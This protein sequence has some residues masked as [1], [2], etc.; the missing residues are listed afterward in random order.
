MAKSG[1][2]RG[3]TAFLVA[4][5]AP[6]LI[7]YL[8]LVAG[9]FFQVFQLA[10]FRFSGVSTKRTFVGFQNFQDLWSEE[11]FW[12]AIRNSLTL[13]LV[14]GPIIL[15]LALALAHGMAGPSRQAKML[16]AVI[17]FPNVLSVVAVALLWR[18]VYNPS[19]GLLRGMG[20][21]G[22]Q[23]GWLG[24]LN[25]AFPAFA[26]AFIWVSVGFYA[27]LFSAAL[28]SIPVEVNE[29]SD[30]EGCTGW[31][32]FVLIT[33]PLLWSV[34]RVA[35]VHVTIATMSVFALVHVMTDG[36]PS[37]RTQTILNYLFRLMTMEGRYGHASAV[38]VINIGILLAASVML[39][40]AMRRDP[41]ESRRK[42]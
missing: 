39:W 27:M 37:E 25:T 20:L 21:T 29:A 6:A 41:T 13:M 33:Y 35:F 40:L 32:R 38:A 36:A 10:T 34:R 17:L 18:S 16:R 42:A 2:R 30:L 28:Q 23:S 22:P 5:L 31:K 1:L 9:P 15:A 19:T 3:R 11:P 8:G 4:C 12:W 26:F 14:V 7:L 24:D